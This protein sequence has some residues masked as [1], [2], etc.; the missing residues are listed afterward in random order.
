[1][2]ISRRDLIR[3]LPAAAL[4]STR[5]AR[6]DATRVEEQDDDAQAQH[7]VADA[8][9]ID[10]TRFPKSAGQTCA[11]CD[12]FDGAAGAAS[13]GCSLFLG[14]DVAAKGWCQGW[15]KKKS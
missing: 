7:Y 15:E 4:G 3:L 14:R 1:M 5:I 10:R 2:P 9:R 12:L 8:A 13:G 11:N 6:A